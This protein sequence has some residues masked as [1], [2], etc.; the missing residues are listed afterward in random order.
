MP[1]VRISL[2][3]AVLLMSLTVGACGAGREQS[4]VEHA[5]DDLYG[6][7]SAR[8]ATK[9]CNLLTP[10]GRRRVAGQAAGG[11]GGTRGACERVLGRALAGPSDRFAQAANVEVSDV[12]VSGNQA[13]A[14]ASL[15]G[16]ETRVGLAKLGGAW[17]VYDLNLRSGR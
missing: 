4:G 7:F 9:A 3:A 6:A 14:T 11:A 2:L 16:W 5:V 15:K 12:K 13:S 1:S 17:R 10:D 8:D